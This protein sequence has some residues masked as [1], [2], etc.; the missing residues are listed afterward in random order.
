MVRHSKVGPG[1]ARRVRRG[2]EIKTLLG[3]GHGPVR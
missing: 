3:I 2:M 1:K